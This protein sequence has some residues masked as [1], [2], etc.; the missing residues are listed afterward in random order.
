MRS[1]FS[2]RAH[3][4]V[5][6]FVP[7]GRRSV[8]LASLAVVA[9]AIVGTASLPA[10][11]DQLA[12]ATCP[13]GP[14]VLQLANPSPGDVLSQGD[15]IVSGLAF[16]PSADAGSGVS[17][18]DLFLGQRDSGGLLLASAV[19]QNDRQWSIKATLPSTTTGQHDFVAYAISSVDGQETSISVPVYVGAAPT[20]TPIP[21]SGSSAASP[22]AL[23]SSTHSSCSAGSSTTTA[24]APAAE[25]PSAPAAQV[26]PAAAVATV[27]GQGPVLSLANPSAGDVLQ[28]G[29][30]MIEGVAFD[31]NATSGN[32]IDRVSVFL[33]NRDNGGTI[34]GTGTP[35]ADHVFK[36]DAKVPAGMTGLHDVFAYAHSSVTDQETVVEV[37]PVYVGVAPTPTPHTITSTTT[38]TS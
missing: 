10:S 3:L 15:Y 29:D 20:P 8:G 25:A 24:S 37:T 30:V 21:S 31:A 38:S 18:I 4:R 16:D 5:P 34:I 17:R 32:G 35:A 1:I 33:G 7:R 27:S 11:A 26:A 9:F 14:P 28:T 23:S 12:I 13:G 22:V 36:I 19:P 6:S 2:S